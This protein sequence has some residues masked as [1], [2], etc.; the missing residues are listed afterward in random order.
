MATVLSATQEASSRI[1]EQTEAALERRFHDAERRREVAQGE[2]DL[3][4]TR[5]R[6]A[7]G[8]LGRLRAGLRDAHATVN[9]G[10]RAM[11]ETFVRLQSMLGA[12]E[13]QLAAIDLGMSQE[14]RG[15][16]DAASF[17]PE[18]PDGP[19]IPGDLGDPRAETSPIRIPD[20][21]VPVAA[22]RPSVGPSNA[23]ER[24]SSLGAS[25]TAGPTQPR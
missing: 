13:G 21:P 25:W 6:E 20:P 22:A 16:E 8:F 1:L 18:G 14:A 7:S 10:R 5:M 3:L 15:R 11:E 19:R 24:Q 2:W 23:D 9:E 12:L 4:R 17:S